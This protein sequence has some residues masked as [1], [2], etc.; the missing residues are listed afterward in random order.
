MANREYQNQLVDDE[1]SPSE[2]EHDGALRQNMMMN[3]EG[4]SSNIL[5]D[6]E[7]D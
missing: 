6:E 4:D 3:I 2:I 5:K 7:D 1:E